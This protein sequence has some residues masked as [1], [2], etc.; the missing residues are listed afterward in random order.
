MSTGPSAETVTPKFSFGP[1]TV[2]VVPF[3]FIVVPLR[4]IL[5]LFILIPFLSITIE[6]SPTIKVII[7][8]AAKIT[9]PFLSSMSSLLASPTERPILA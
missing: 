3:M 9:L 6:E 2:F 1:T 8:S 7:E 5:E 4:L